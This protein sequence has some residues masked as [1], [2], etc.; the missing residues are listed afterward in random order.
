MID[1]LIPLGTGSLYDN[2]ELRYSLRS[3]EAHLKNIGNIYIVGE[4]P[5]WLDNFIHIPFKEQWHASKNIMQK[6]LMA[7]HHPWLSDNF[8]FWNDDFFCIADI[9]AEL[10]P[11]YHRGSLEDVLEKNKGNWYLEYVTA[12]IDEL[13]ARNLK[14]NN[15]DLHV[16]IIYNKRKFMDVM[17][18]YDFHK[19]LTV[20]SIYC[21]SLGI[22][23]T[24][25]TDCKIYGWKPMGQ[26][27]QQ[28]EGRNLFSTGDQCLENPPGRLSAVRELLQTKFKTPSKYE[29]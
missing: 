28:I 8:L 29:R 23:G 3:V 13:K 21:N 16:P 7:C 5:A 20:K 24:E 4:C 27:M 22:E 17:S 18:H 15:F 14:M 1:L 25:T 10:Y 9:D 11:Y 12:T 2:Y 19:K 26:L 6:I